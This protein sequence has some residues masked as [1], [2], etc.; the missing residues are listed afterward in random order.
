MSKHRVRL[1]KWDN[2]IL[3]SVNHFF[4][5]YEEAIEFANN[6]DSQGVKIY[7]DDGELVQSMSPAP[8]A[9]T[10]ADAS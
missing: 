7:N 4:D 9:D 8:V 2:G 10:S 3:R 1:H 6:S 5:S